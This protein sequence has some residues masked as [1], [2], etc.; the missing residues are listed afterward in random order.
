MSIESICILLVEDNVGD[1]WLIQQLVAEV[2]DPAI[3]VEVAEQL[4]AGLSRLDVESFQAVLLDLSLPDSQGLDTFLQVRAHAPDVPIVIL[5][6]L[7]D[8]A[9]GRIAVREGAQDYLVKGQVDS[10]RL[11]RAL[12]YAITRQKLQTE[13][14]VQSLQD[15]LTGLYNRRGFLTLAEQH[16]KLAYRTNRPFL[17][18][19]GDMDGLKKINDTL[20]HRLGDAALRQT[21]K[22]LQQTFREADIVA[23]LGG[24]EFIVLVT[25]APLDRGQGL[26]ARLQRNI[27]NYNRREAGTF[28]LSLSVGAA[29]FDPA[30]PLGL[31]ELISSADTAMY[32]QKVSRPKE[33]T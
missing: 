17:L 6:G 25:E 19:F 7:A 27:K 31:D 1:S 30:E 11:V 3:Q 33:V 13:F 29:Y 20:G 9:L 8:E 18:I 32:A 5:T 23:R 12:T 21:A 10:A 4:A 16:W 22:I 24:D 2:K 26:L 14:R 15:D 28:T